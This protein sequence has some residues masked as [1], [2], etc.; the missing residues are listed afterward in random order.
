MTGYVEMFGTIITLEGIMWN[1]YCVITI[2]RL[3]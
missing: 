3:R 2:T 1:I